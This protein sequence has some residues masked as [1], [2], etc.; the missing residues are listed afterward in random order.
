MTVLDLKQ[1]ATVVGLAAA[2][3][4][5]IYGQPVSF[6]ATVTAAAAPVTSGTVAFEAGSTILAAAVP[7][8]AAGQAAFSI[9]TLAASATPY[10][11]TAL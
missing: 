10:V 7:L 9:S 3:N 1:A 11:I 6:T 2:P 8:N 5:S 4:P